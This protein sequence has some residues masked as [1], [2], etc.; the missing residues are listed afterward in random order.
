MTTIA[1]GKA[2]FA[3]D[4]VASTCYTWYKAFGDLTN[5]TKTPLFVLHGGPAAGHEYLLSLH[6]LS[7]L[8]IFYDQLGCG[9]ST[10]LPEK[11]KDQSFWTPK[12]FCDELTNLIAH[13]GLENRRIDLLGHSW[14]GMLA[15]EWASAPSRAGNLRRLVL[16][17]VPA[18]MEGYAKGLT[19]VREGLPQEAQEAIRRGLED[20]D[21][22]SPEY[23]DAM[24]VFSQTH[25]NLSNP[26]PSEEIAPAL[27][28][29][30]TS[31]IHRTMFGPTT[32]LPTGSL[33]TWS[34]IPCLHQIKAA[35]LLI[36]GSEEYIQES[37]MQ[38]FFD[39][40]PK[41]KWITYE[42]AARFSHIEQREKFFGQ[43]KHFLA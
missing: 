3:V 23:L 20:E 40:I 34:S 1:E 38:P 5:T 33:Q 42:N 30:A 15:V 19:K 16:Y 11:S 29:M 6:T 12:L 37:V 43:V 7:D 24:G 27:L 25:L 32:F 10:Q 41:I 36:R 2:P 4:G 39:Y 28:H 35:T 14:G 21:Y 26:F 18:S 22:S 8:V 31:E 9:Q 17:G 13:L